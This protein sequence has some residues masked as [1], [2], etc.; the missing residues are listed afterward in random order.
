MFEKFRIALFIG[1]LL[2]LCTVGVVESKAIT[3]HETPSE[4]EVQTAFIYNFFKFIQWPNKSESDSTE[5]YLLC[6]LG[7]GSINKHLETLEEKKVKGRK[8]TFKRFQKLEDVTSCHALFI[9]DS[10]DYGISDV[11]THL[12]D[13]PVLT[14][15][16]SE[17]LAE[18]GVMINF[19]V[20]NKRIK[21][22]INHQQA[23]KHGL[24]ISSKLL[25][26]GRVIK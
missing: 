18:L 20:V 15:G 3:H 23:K 17:G 16:N 8:I 11:L 6:A 4:D 19:I 13:V 2:S 24:M 12:R 21:F 14:I 25:R 9:N 22:E 1:I 10:K 7:W 5:H 26:L